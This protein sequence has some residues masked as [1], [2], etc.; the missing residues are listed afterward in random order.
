MFKIYVDPAKVPAETQDIA[1]DYPF[2]VED[3]NVGDIIKIESG[4]MDVLVKE[5]TQDALVV[6]ALHSMKNMKQRRHIN[7]PG[8]KLRLPGL[9]DQDKID[10]KFAIEQG[11]DYIAMSFVRSKENIQELRDLLAANNGSHIQIISKIENQEA[12]DNLDEIII[13][14]DGVMVARGDLGI[15]VPVET[16]PVHQRAIVKKCKAYGKYVIVATHM[17][18][19]MIENPFPTRAEVGDIFNALVQKADAIMLSGETTIGK[20]PIQSVEMMKKIALQAEGTLEYKHEDYNSIDLTQR[21][22]EKKRLIRSAVHIAESL[23]AKG[24]VTFTKTGRLARLAAAYRPKCP[25]FAFT[26][27]ERTFTNTTILFGVVA[28]HMPFKHHADVLKDAIAKL[29]ERGDVSMEDQVVVVSDI[30]RNDKEIPVLEI[31][32]VKDV[33]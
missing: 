3:L 19:S 30:L 7:L 31:V 21:D 2:L 13:N 26:N 29:V 5:K 23:G 25:V 12:L 1:C 18:E 32:S 9:I 16:L 24:I 33:L 28:R 10:A 8:V 11:F 6:E 27:Q 14:S 22:L 15:E 4:L 20:F 17:L